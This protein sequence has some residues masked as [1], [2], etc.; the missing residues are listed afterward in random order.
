MGIAAGPDGN[1]WFSDVVGNRIGRI[2]TAG[3]ISEFPVPTANSQPLGIT[4]GPDG[5]PT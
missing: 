1:L 5:Q 4:A 2:S 3:T